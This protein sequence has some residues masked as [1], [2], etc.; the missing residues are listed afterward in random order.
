MNAEYWPIITSVLM[1]AVTY[2]AMRAD[3]KNLREKQ[4]D[5]Q[6][7]AASA[8]KRLDDHIERHHTK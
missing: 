5:I 2:G 6:T 8:H 3:L 4:G 7:L 1:A